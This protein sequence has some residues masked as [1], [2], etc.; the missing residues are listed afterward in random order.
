MILKLFLLFTLV[1]GILLITPGLITD[2]CGLVFL[3]PYSRRLVREYIK[4]VLKQNLD[5]GRIFI[6]KV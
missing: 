3:I 4:R 6:R 1:A 5:S 2:A